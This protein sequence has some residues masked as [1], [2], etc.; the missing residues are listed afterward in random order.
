MRLNAL[1]KKLVGYEPD[2]LPFISIYI[3]AEVAGGGR[4]TF[5]IWLKGAL[6]DAAQ[7]FKEDA[8]LFPLYQEAAERINAF[9]DDE[10]DTDASGIAIF[11]S[12]GDPDFFETVELKVPFPENLL[13]DLDRP[14]IF[15][16]A[17][18]ISQN[19]SYAVLWASSTEAEIYAFGG[20]ARIRVDIDADE[21]LETVKGKNINRTKVGGWSQQRYQ[22]RMDKFQLQHAKET[23]AEL[24]RI[25]SERNIERL[26]VCGDEATILPVLVPQLSKPMEDKLV[27][28]LSLTQY[29]EVDEIRE[30]TAEL[31]AST[32]A[33]RDDEML[34]QVVT[35][36]KSSAGL[37]S[38]GF[39]DTLRALSNGQVQELALAADP[40]DIRFRQRAAE[41][42]IEEYAPGDDHSA[43]DEETIPQRRE[44]MV[45]QLIVRAINSDAE[46]HF[47]EGDAIVESMGGVGAILRYS[48]TVSSNA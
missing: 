41:K 26:I 27:G 19:A 11:L 31:I 45:D 7:P 9:I 5:P 16:L 14:Y 8:D 13:L 3:N 44:E 18:A 25:M 2:G 47:V 21:H 46:I 43:V 1:M 22:R 38:L 28:T 29:H 39:E 24:E 42:V 20:E 4:E 34:E 23:V 33:E 40:N 37:G 10:L 36:A 6:S 15:P 32:R 12:L 17:R 48:M 30:Q 35:A